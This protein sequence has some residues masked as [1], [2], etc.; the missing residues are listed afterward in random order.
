[1]IA[2]QKYENDIKVQVTKRLARKDVYSIIKHFLGQR[3]TFAVSK[4]DGEYEVW[5]QILPGDEPR[6]KNR[7]EGMTPSGVIA[8]DK[9]DLQQRNFVCIWDHGELVYGNPEKI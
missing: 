7:K 3:I 9:K 2:I 5:R 6:V 4:Y 8:Q 1:V